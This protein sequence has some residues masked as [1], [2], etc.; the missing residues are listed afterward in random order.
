MF[1]KRLEALKER[2]FRQIDEGEVLLDLDFSGNESTFSSDLIIT[3]WSNIAFEASFCTLRPSVFINTPMKV[4]N[5]N[6]EQYGLPVVNITLRDVVGVSV[7]VDDIPSL[8]EIA[9]RLLREKDLY[10]EQ[11]K[12]AVQDYLF[13]PGRSGEAGGRYIIDQL[14]GNGESA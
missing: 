7:D 6:Y 3:D 13:H 2:Y 4:M 11:I 5:P 9:E 10:R 1:P 8:G 14:K 12:Q